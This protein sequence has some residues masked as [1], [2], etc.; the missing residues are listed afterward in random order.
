M[1]RVHSSIIS[2]LWGSITIFVILIIDD[3]Q[4]DVVFHFLSR[5]QNL[6][7]ADVCVLDL[8]TWIKSLSFYHP[9]LKGLY[10]LQ[11]F[12][13][14]ICWQQQCLCQKHCRSDHLLLFPFSDQDTA[15]WRAKPER[16]HILEWSHWDTELWSH[17]SISRSLLYQT[18]HKEDLN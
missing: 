4:K 5:Y 3:L 15:F 7:Y 10:L 13:Q 12:F 14:N 17:W 11:Y 9:S 2:I 16:I 18:D 1:I 6:S 8:S